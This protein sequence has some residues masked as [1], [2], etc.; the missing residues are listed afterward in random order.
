MPRDHRIIDLDGVQAP[1][2]AE[3]ECYSMF[4]ACEN[5][6]Y[7]GDTDIPRG[8]KVTDA[9]CPEC[10]CI[11]IFKAKPV[12]PAEQDVVPEVAIAAPEP[13]PTIEDLLREA[14]RLRPRPQPEPWHHH[15]LDPNP[16]PMFPSN[17]PMRSPD[18]WMGQPPMQGMTTQGPSESSGLVAN[19]ASPAH[20]RHLLAAFGK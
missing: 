16:H 5:C 18:I 14:D 6:D 7:E 20:N 17:Q 10:G 13:R 1:D 15:T 12:M 3:V 19:A 4:C 9:E 2:A 11:T 8:T